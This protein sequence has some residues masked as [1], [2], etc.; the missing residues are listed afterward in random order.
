MR[1]QDLYAIGNPGA[2]QSAA[3]EAGKAQPTEGVGLEGERSG[4]VK[5]AAAESDR[6]QLSDLTGRLSRTLGADHP[7]RAAR[8][9]RL[10]VE[11]Q[12]GRYRVD[13]LAISRSLV[14]EALRG[15]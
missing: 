9:E 2:S 4:G 15:G 13:A 5:E 7:E 3:T 1:V 11:V 14:D 10:A 8:L 6:V 12:A